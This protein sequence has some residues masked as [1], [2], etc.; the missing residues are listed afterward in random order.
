MIIL[1]LNGDA[2][3]PVD[4]VIPSLVIVA[5]LTLTLDTPVL[6]IELDTIDA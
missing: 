6:R 5:E 4:P 3:D 1:L 2:G